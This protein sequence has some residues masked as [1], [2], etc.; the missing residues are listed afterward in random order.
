MTPHYFD[1]YKGGIGEMLKRKKINYEKLT[2]LTK[3]QRDALALETEAEIKKRIDAIIEKF[4]DLKT[5]LAA[6]AWETNAAAVLEK[7]KSFEA[8][9]MKHF[10]ALSPRSPYWLYLMKF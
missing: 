3:Q 10:A 2:S 6:R 8:E 9:L 4:S 5:L 1:Y 7:M